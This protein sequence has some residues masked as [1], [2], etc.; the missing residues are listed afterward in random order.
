M[1]DLASDARS[2]QFTWEQAVQYQGGSF[3]LTTPA[4]DEE[5]IPEDEEKKTEAFDGW[6]TWKNANRRGMEYIVNFRKRGNRITVTAE[7][8]SQMEH[9]MQMIKHQQK[10]ARQR[11]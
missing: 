3:V 7:N 4:M 2:E 8:I 10:M 5:R 1:K 6:D 9:D 11:E